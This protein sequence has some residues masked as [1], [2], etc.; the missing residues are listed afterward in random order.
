MSRSS[1]GEHGGVRGN[2]VG[3]GPRKIELALQ[4]VGRSLATLDLYLSDDEARDIIT[5]S[6]GHE[7]D[8]P[9][10]DDLREQLGGWMARR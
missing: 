4:R 1:A 9:V 5:G 8:D 7:I 6:S 2:G 10:V 3:A